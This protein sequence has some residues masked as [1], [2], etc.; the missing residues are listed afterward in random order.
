MYVIWNT[1]QKY[2]Y[3]LTNY[4]FSQGDIGKAMLMVSGS[5]Q[6]TRDIIGFTNQ[7]H[8]DNAKSNM[9]N[10]KQ[11][12]DTYCEA[13]KKTLVGD[14]EIA[15]YNKIESAMAAYN[16]KQAEVL[17]LG[18]TINSEQSR[19]AQEMAVTELDPLY[20]AL[21]QAWTDLMSMNVDTGNELSEDLSAQGTFSLIVSVVITAAAL[22]VSVI[23]G[24]IISKGISDP[25]KKCV[26]RLLKLEEGDL[27]TPVPQAQSTDEAGVLLDTL[28]NTV[29]KLSAMIK[30]TGYLLGEM[31]EGN[32]DV[33]TREED[34][35][36]GEFRQLLVSMRK[37]N[38]DMSL[39]LGQ[40]N[41]SA[42]QVASG[43][44]QVSVGAQALSQGATEQASSIE[45]L[46][47]TI[48]EISGQVKHNADNAKNASEKTNTVSREVND[49]N[50]R[51]QDMLKAMSNISNT[52]NEIGKIIKTI[53]DIAFQTNIL[54]LN[55]AVEAA[56]AGEAGKGFAVVADEV[57][58]LASKSAEASKNTATL[59]E[60]SLQ[61]VENGTKIAD[62][63][64]HSL[65]SVVEGV[66][67]ITGIINTIAKASETQATSIGQV[68]QGIDQISGVVQT[69]SATAE[70]SAAASE[71]LSG[72]AQILKDLVKKFK[73]KAVD[74]GETAR[75]PMIPD[76]RD[77][78][79][80]APIT[81]YEKY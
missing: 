17:S 10:N 26:E 13:V 15:Q 36:V 28:R 34:K 70:E 80:A 75:A 1:N 30:D 33:K 16:A 48:S 72:Q 60:G 49:S 66:K 40:I 22:A 2:S 52:S 32:Y 43:S 18:D 38:R 14:S 11:K 67:E 39:I 35:Y 25:I 64:A 27:E 46:A 12:Y 45:E 78:Q 62:D 81:E 41:E 57:R 44:E 21:Y 8:I 73:L 51:M 68:T 77:M 61:A 56:R 6:Y 65:S 23:L 69:N 47:A 58:N 71:E 9:N 29:H 19:L 74:P 3:A 24:V 42:G 63:T 50:Q 20:D 7:E 79:K 5:Q 59:I 37:L 31:A 76:R 4:G 53:E 55:A 54:A